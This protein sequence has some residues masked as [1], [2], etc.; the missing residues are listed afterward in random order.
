MMMML[1]RSD[2][3]AD[4]GE[5]TLTLIFSLAEVSKKSRPRLSASCFPLSYDITCTDNCNHYHDTV[6]TFIMSFLQK[7]SLFSNL[8]PSLASYSTTVS[9]S[10]SSSSSNLPVHPPC[11]I[12]YRLVWPE[13]RKDCGSERKTT[14]ILKRRVKGGNKTLHCTYI[15]RILV[16]KSVR[17]GKRNV[18]NRHLCVIPTICL[19]LGTPGVSL[20]RNHFILLTKENVE[21]TSGW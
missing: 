20:I 6:I 11:R 3:D 2:D 17:I 13:K 5:R 12:C 7:R 16:S 4:D 1:E 21:Q 10:S 9:S 8:S 18:K 15:I 19:D 14:F